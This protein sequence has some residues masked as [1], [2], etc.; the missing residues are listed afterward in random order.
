LPLLVSGWPRPLR[1]KVSEEGG[2]GG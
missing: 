2:E 1:L